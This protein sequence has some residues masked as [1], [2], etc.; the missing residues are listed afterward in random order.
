MDILEMLK[1]GK[2][3]YAGNKIIYYLCKFLFRYSNT[4]FISSF[5][6]RSARLSS[7]VVSLFIITKCFP[8]K[9]CINDEAG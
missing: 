6:I 9:N 8:W 2:K 7:G 3:T 5:M 1:K 4:S